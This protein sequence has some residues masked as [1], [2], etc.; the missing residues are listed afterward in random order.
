MNK[1]VAY[2]KWHSGIEFANGE[3][4]E[5]EDIVIFEAENAEIAEEYIEQRKWITASFGETIN[6]IHSYIQN[7]N[8][9]RADRLEH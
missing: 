2:I 7:Q 1:Y 4:E 8:N 9:F 6:I 5:Y 3:Y